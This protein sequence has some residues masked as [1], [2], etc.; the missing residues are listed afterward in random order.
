LLVTELVTFRTE[1]GIN[2]DALLR[3]PEQAASA[4]TAVLYLHGKGGSFCG[5]P[6]RF[7]PESLAVQ[8]EPWHHLAINMRMHSLGFSRR[9]GPG[10]PHLTNTP[11]QESSV[12]GG[13]WERITEGIRDVK[14]AVGWLRQRGYSEIF[15]V[16]KSSGGYYATQYAAEVGNISGVVLLSPVHTHRMP[17]PTWFASDQ[18]RDETVARA[19]AMV[20]SGQGHMLIPLPEWYFGICAA[21]LVERADE[22]EGIWQEWARNIHVPLLGVYGGAEVPD[23]EIWHAGYAS[24]ASAIQQI[25]EL[26]GADHSYLG[27]EALVAGSVASFIRDVLTEDSSNAKNPIA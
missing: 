27:S 8:G 9:N 25:V 20:D 21:S 26:P 23:T 1:D 14:A 22:P 13:M 18:E 17:F 24:G 19:R 16:G 10:I 12:G 11:P 15:V 2:L 5:G 6:G 7:I 3:H 4:D